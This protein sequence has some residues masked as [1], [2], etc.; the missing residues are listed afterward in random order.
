LRQFPEF[1]AFL[2]P[3]AS[4]Q[5]DPAVPINDVEGPQ[6]TATPE[7]AIQQAETQI[8][9][10]LRGSILERIAELSPLSLNDL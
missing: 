10:S 1:L 6:T 3:K 7:E 4:G 9:S 2:A 8:L 5:D